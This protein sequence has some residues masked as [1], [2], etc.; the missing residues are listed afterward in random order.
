M[1]VCALGAQFGT[2]LH[3]EAVLLIDH[4]QLQVLELHRSLN[5]SMRADHDADAAVSQTP[6]DDVLLSLRRI[7]NQQTDLLRLNGCSRA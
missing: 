2:L 6:A 1:R 7:P 4:S 3:A 5:H